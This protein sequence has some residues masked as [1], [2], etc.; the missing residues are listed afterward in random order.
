MIRRQA[1]FFGKV[2]SGEW[3]AMR[4]YVE[5]DLAPLWRDFTGATSVQILFNEDHGADA[6][7]VLSIDYET[8]SAIDQAMNSS[9]RFKSRDLLP[10]FYKR[11]FEK[12][13]L[14]HYQFEIT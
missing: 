9:A 3:P 7:L 2:K 11:F 5:S 4:R 13:T 14:T 10:A 12:V 6:P 8:Q 1:I